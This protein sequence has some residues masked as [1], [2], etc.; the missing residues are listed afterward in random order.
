MSR[1]WKFH[2]TVSICVLVIA[3]IISWLF[4]AETSPFTEYFEDSVPLNLWRGLH[5]IP[6]L[7]SVVA[8]GHAGN[9]LAF[10]VVFVIQWLVLGLL[11]SYVILGFRH[12]PSKP[13]SIFK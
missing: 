9:Y 11:L 10:V 7:A 3:S 13:P 6:F 5:L 4:A 2:L 1:N 8:G 12:R